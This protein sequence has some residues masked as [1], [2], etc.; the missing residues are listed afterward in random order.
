VSESSGL[1]ASKHAILLPLVFVGILLAKTVLFSY[2]FSAGLVS[3]EIY[4][5]TS[6]RYVLYKL[7]LLPEFNPPVSSSYTVEN[8]TILINATINDNLLGL[9]ILGGSYNWLNFEHPIT[10]KLIYAIIYLL[11]GS[12]VAIRVVQLTFSA[13]VLF[14]MFRYFISRYGVKA[15]VP[16]TI[17][18]V[19]D[20]TYHHLMHLAF[21][22]TLMIDVL[23]LGTY[24][25]LEKRDLLGSILIAMTP[26]F[27]EVAIIFSLAVLLY[28]Y[29][30]GKHHLLKQT[31]LVTV[32]SVVVGYAPYLFF[33]PPEQI[34]GAIIGAINIVDPFACSYACLLTFSFKWGVFDFTP[35]FAWIWF[36]GLASATFKEAKGIS[37]INEEAVPYALSLSLI[38]FLAVIQFKRAVYPFYF[39]PV[40]VLSIFPMKDLEDFFIL[41]LKR[42]FFIH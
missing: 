42:R 18:V 20:G 5:V 38:L 30:T 11:T 17:L 27:K 40:I 16:L 4:Y 8:N 36:A 24:F 2:L 41:F 12:V 29:T 3:D 14:L 31:V 33:V 13:F 32:A 10:V 39:A 37:S 21:L 7:G 19:A 22:D 26:L 1:K 35:F 25:M 6:A 28:L 34:I 15:I 9:N 23:L